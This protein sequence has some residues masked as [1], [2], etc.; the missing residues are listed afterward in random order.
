MESDNCCQ[1]IKVQKQQLLKSSFYLLSHF[2]LSLNYEKP[3]YSQYSGLK[4][5]EKGRWTPKGWTVADHTAAS[6]DLAQWY[7]NVGSEGW[8][9]GSGS[10]AVG[11]HAVD[12]DNKNNSS[13]YPVT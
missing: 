4:Y 13:L 9:S 8:L 7:T 2:W 11:T 10:G 3:L 12:G 5:Q 6:K 1:H